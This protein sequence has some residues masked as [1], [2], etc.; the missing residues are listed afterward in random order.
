MKI[1]KILIIEARPIRRIFAEV[2]SANK[3][4]KK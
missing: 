2:L 4:F 3:L 1:N